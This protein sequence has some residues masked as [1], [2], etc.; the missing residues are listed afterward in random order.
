LR[1]ASTPETGAG[2]LTNLTAPHEDIIV[3]EEE[4]EEED[5]SFPALL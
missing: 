3:L 4:E 2:V 5:I 1:T